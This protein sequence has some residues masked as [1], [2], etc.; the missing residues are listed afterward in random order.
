MSAMAINAGRRRLLQQ[1]LTA[2]SASLL[3]GWATAA[4]SSPRL[5]LPGNYRGESWL[6]VLD[7]VS[8]QL[9][10]RT[11]L[12]QR[13]HGVLRYLPDPELFLVFSRRPGRQIWLVDP[14]QQRIVQ[15]FEA[16]DNRHFF[17]HG[18]WWQGKLV[19]SENDTDTGQGRLSLREPERLQVLAEMTSGGLGPHELLALPDQRIAVANGGLLTLPETGRVKLNRASMDPNLAYIDL[20]Q[21]QVLS[22]HRPVDRRL[23]VRHLALTPQGK[24]AIAMQDESSLGGQQPLLSV[25]GGELQ[26]PVIEL[27]A[28][29]SAYRGYAASISCQGNFLAVSFPKAGKIGFWQLEPWQFVGDTLLPGGAGLAATS[30]GFWLSSEQGRIER[31]QPTLTSSLS[32]ARHPGWQWDNHAYWL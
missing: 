10:S 4:A 26:L 24:V 30:D 29:W 6:A 32:S 12:P 18:L 2:F 11:L 19:V 23:S 21:Q 9:L 20:R 27:A 28:G 14:R 1:A 7:P 15:T 25:H 22:V 17:G 5:L 8:L 16:A 13:A 3:P 31:W